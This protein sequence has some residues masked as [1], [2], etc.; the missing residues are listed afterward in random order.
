MLPIKLTLKGIY[1]YREEQIIEFDKLTEAHI[2][3]IFGAVG[4]GKSTILEAITFALYGETERLNRNERSYNMMNLKSTEMKVDFEFNV[5]GEEYRVVVI[6][7]R[8]K[9]F[10]EVDPPHKVY[11]KKKAGNWEA[12]EDFKISGI[13]G[14]SYDNFRRT[15]IIPQGKFQEFLQ[16]SATDRSRM[17]SEI[18]NLQ[19]YDLASKVKLVNDKNDDEILIKQTQLSELGN[20]GR[21]ILQDSENEIIELTKQTNTRSTELLV[22]RQEFQN[23]EILKLAFEKQ[24]QLK[25]QLDTLLDQ[26]NSML[27]KAKI[28]ADYEACQLAFKSLFDQEISLQKDITTQQNQVKALQHEQV[29]LQKSFADINVQFVNIEQDNKL[30]ETKRTK[31]E[32]LIRISEIIKASHDAEEFEK[33]KL[34]G[35]QKFE[36]LQAKQSQIKEQSKNI[37][38][39]IKTQRSALPDASLISEISVWFTNKNNFINS[40]RDLNEQ[41]TVSQIQHKEFISQ[42][43]DLFAKSGFAIK[44]P[45][46]IA[47]LIF[48]TDNEISEINQRAKALEVRHQLEQYAHNLHDGEPC[49]LCGALEHPDVLKSGQA[50]ADLLNLKQEIENKQS[51]FRKIQALQTAISQVI[52][53]ESEAEKMLLQLKLKTAGEQKALTDFTATFKFKGFSADDE[54]AA[55]NLQEK[56]K[57][58][59]AQILAEESQ[60]EKILQEIEQRET[61]I[62][63]FEDGF[64]EIDKRIDAA[65]QKIEIRQA[66][67]KTLKPEDFKNQ[68]PSVLLQQAQTIQ[69]Q[70]IET[71]NQFQLIEH[72]R[73]QVKDLLLKNETT[74]SFSSQSLDKSKTRLAGLNLQIDSEIKKG[75]FG[76]R[77]NILQLLQQNINI[78]AEKQLVDKFNQ[79]LAIANDRLKES[80]TFLEGKTFADHIYITLQ[81]NLIDAERILKELESQKSIVIN[82]L[83]ENKHK[84]E[85]VN[86]ITEELVQLSFRKDNL[87]VLSG[88]FR[89][90]GFV[91]Y[92]SNIYLQQLCNAANGRFHKL[93]R[94]SLQLEVDDKENLNVRDFLNDGQVR[95]VKTLSGGQTFQSSLCL[96]LALAD[97]IQILTRSERNFF[98]LD[99]GFGSLD[100]ESLQT[101]F[102]TL[103]SLRKENRI[104]GV[105]SHVEDLQ[106]EIDNYLTIKN[107]PETGSVVK[108]S[109]E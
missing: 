2:F 109:W 95:S 100:K 12:Q 65:K 16:L 8:K 58:G 47:A 85:R 80:N 5:A 14:L 96:A 1:S 31:A 17:L 77:E 7:K 6:Q 44:D 35:L 11:Y 32:D 74:L 9:K 81:Q 103:K 28:L 101:V 63:K 86:K 82:K 19:K 57:S 46:Q 45:E 71:E 42:K 30:K 72:K 107:D 94:Q 49:P 102:E 91:R 40:I 97:S 25:T 108:G 4:S 90:S 52:F 70:I 76:S 75:T 92:V 22:L 69:Q 98:F 36:E 39:Q 88:L 66:E 29:L 43:E 67:M 51:D 78:I 54:K 24:I 13:I 38:E 21:S 87:N 83:E 104:V 61:E 20:I 89:Q 27:V 48:T 105:I 73:D 64:T 55:T 23:I 62:K 50:G 93:T 15:I 10:L 26:K 59:Q 18:F 106:Q 56:L 99:E 79:D 41:E 34:A 37:A 84:L 33:R 60:L 53:K 3:G 68:E